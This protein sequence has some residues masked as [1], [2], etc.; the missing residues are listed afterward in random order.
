MWIVTGM[1]GQRPVADVG[2]FS[3]EAIALSAPKTDGR[4]SGLYPYSL[5]LYLRSIVGV[6]A[7][8]QGAG[9]LAIEL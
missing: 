7:T 9:A 5:S 6:A 4:W 2:N 1:T 3:E 8:V